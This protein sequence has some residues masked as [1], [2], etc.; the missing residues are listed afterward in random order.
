MCMLQKPNILICTFLMG[1]LFLLTM[2][3]TV[4]ASAVDKAEEL[5]N[6]MLFQ[7]E[8]MKPGD[9]TTETYTVSNERQE[10]THYVL[11]SRFSG[12]SKKFYNQ[13]QLTV[14]QGKDTLFHGQL[15]EFQGFGI[16]TLDTGEETQ[17]EF[18]VDFPYGSGN[19]FQG[20]VTHFDILVQAE[21][22]MEDTAVFHDNRL[23]NTASMIFTY[24]LIGA[25]FLLVGG[26]LF[27]HTYKRN[28]I[29]RNG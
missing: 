23:P 9:W 29:V 24:L 7:I 25:A 2:P 16:K 11:A 21:D 3:W 6:Q 13:L 19:E 17:F 4:T 14:K 10:N 1:I 18:R 20:L 8:N 22:R 28:K 5:P 12:E 26:L 15:A 27:S